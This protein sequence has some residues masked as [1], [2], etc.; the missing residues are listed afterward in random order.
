MRH[1]HCIGEFNVRVNIHLHGK[2]TLHIRHF[3]RDETAEADVLHRRGGAKTAELHT[4]GDKRAAN[5]RESGN[6]VRSG[7]RFC[8]DIGGE[9]EIGQ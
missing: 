6:V 7:H 5:W 4:G 9:T 8:D 1:T 2:R 3:G